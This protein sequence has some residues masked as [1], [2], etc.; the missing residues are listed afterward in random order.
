M[1]VSTFSSV[2][3]NRFH[4]TLKYG[5]RNISLG[6]IERAL[7]TDAIMA[8]HNEYTQELHTPIPIF[9]INCFLNHALYKSLN[10]ALIFKM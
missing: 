2:L 7:Y 6:Y 10:V 8:L 9:I 4:C 3:I 1:Q 5:V